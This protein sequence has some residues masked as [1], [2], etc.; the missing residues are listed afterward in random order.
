MKST[1]GPG[2]EPHRDGQVMGMALSG[3]H[4]VCVDGDT[5]SEAKGGYKHELDVAHHFSNCNHITTPDLNTGF[6]L[7]QE[8]FPPVT[9]SGQGWSEEEPQAQA[10]AE[11]R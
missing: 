11:L 3:T 8:L 6:L 2:E 7:N 4:W 10:T 1:L 9:T 5:G